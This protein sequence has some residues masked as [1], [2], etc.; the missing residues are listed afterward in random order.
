MIRDHGCFSVRINRDARTPAREQNL[1]FR[2]NFCETLI[3]LCKFKKYYNKLGK[4][5]FNSQSLL[6]IEKG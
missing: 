6:K 2:F 5:V 1:N 3:S 4:N